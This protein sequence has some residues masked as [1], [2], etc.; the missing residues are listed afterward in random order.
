M[1]KKIA[2]IPAYD[3]AGTIERIVSESH[4]FADWVIVCDD[5]SNDDTGML[6]SQAGALVLWIPHSG[7]GEALRTLFK[8]AIKMNAEAVFSIDADGQHD[9][10]DIPKLLEA[11]KDADMVIGGR[12]GIP[13][14]RAF[15][16]IL[17]SG[18]GEFD[19]QSG[20]KAIRGSV[21]QK[22]IPSEMGYA[23]DAEIFDKA[24]AQGLRITQVAVRT[25][26]DAPAKHSMSLH[27]LDVALTTFKLATFR[28]PL[29]LYGIPGLAFIL[30]SIVFGFRAYAMSLLGLGGFSV[31]IT[32]ALF[33]IYLMLIGLISSALGILI[34]TIVTMERRLEK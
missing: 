6:A 31:A 30:V 18:F 21:L 32:L 12:V 1:G 29:I 15:G 8:E 10:A 27:F 22:L 5:G 26:Y 2:L 25:N 7:K 20:F 23:S 4:K 33:S 3:E 9:P 19:T 16:N 11:L 17:L 34:W 24:K 28:H 14:V 13:M